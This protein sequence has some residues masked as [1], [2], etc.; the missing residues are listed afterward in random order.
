[1]TTQVQFRRG[2]TSQHGSFTGAVGEVTVDTDLDTL[3]VHDGAVAGGVRIAKFTDIA[4]QTIDISDSSSNTISL[5]PGSGDITFIGDDI[6]IAA[7][8]NTMTF[9]LNNTITV[10]QISSGNSTGITLNDD[11]LLAGTLRAEDSGAISV[12]GA[13]Q[14]SGV[15]TGLTIEATGDTAAND[16]AAMGYTAAEGLILTGQGSTNDVTIKN[17]ADADV[18]EIPTGTTNVTIAGTLGTGGAITATGSFIIGSADLNEADLEKLDGITNGTVAAA[19]AVVVDGNLDASGFRNV[20]ATGSFIIGS[21]DMNET[22]LEKLDGITNGTAAANKAVVIDGSKN[23]GT[24]GAVT[25]TTFVIGSAD[26]NETDLE[27]IDGITNGTV[28]ANKAVVAD[29]NLDVGT[30]RNVNMSGNLDVGGDLQLDGNLTVSGT[31]QSVNTTTLE[32]T[33]SLIELSKNNS[34]GSDL[35]AGILIN[36][37]SAG[38]NAAFYWNEGDDK[39][40]AV[41]STSV[42]TATSVTDSSQATIVASLEGTTVVGGTTTLNA[43][44]ITN[45][46]G[47][48]SFGNENLTTT[49]TINGGVITGTGFTIGSAAMNETDLEKIDGITNGTVAANKAVVADANKD[50][51]TFRNCTATTF[52]GALTGNA[53]TATVLA[54][55]RTLG[56]VS[57]NGSA[58]INLPGVNAAGNQNTSGTAAIGTAVTVTA[59]NTANETCFITFVDGATG[60]QGIE[61][62]TGLNYNPSTNVLA[63]TASA[64]QYS[65]VAEKYVGDAQYESGTVVIFGG[66]H[67]V[68]T[69]EL[70]H[71]PRV[72]GVVSTAP[73]YLMNSHL[74]ATYVIDLALTGRVPCK[75]KGVVAKGDLIVSSQTAG[76]GMKLQQESYNVGCVIGK[77]LEDKDT[78]DVGVIEVVVGRL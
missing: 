60:T 10:D 35:D 38:N 65:D 47:A 72:A 24:L 4:T 1:M 32:I 44:T 20:T 54:T 31:T 78:V 22:D 17:D 30:F 61:T 76:V 77:A 16:N 11:L 26:I 48:I 29:A 39:F 15:V 25:A 27:K 43:A 64:A 8:G 58:N 14:I 45:S 13:M 23:I 36:R 66:D 40:K 68:T 33:D 18:I 3:R 69:T 50:V 46:T 55:A 63:T 62:D 42:G 5:A 70:T 7:A 56:G 21:A 74:E 67:E 49:G 34:G 57:F 53:D 6:T 52:I 19:K 75:V 28:A 41:L 9:T 71:D 73:A 59:N 37:G 2:T 12:D 51:T